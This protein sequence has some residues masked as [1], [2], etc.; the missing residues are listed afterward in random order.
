MLSR[1]I[2]EGPAG[3]IG[4]VRPPARRVGRRRGEATLTSPWA[5]D[6]LHPVPFPVLDAESVERSPCIQG[7]GAGRLR[8]PPSA[9]RAV[10]IGRSIP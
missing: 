1:E 6:T 7:A 2:M 3:S 4:G 8:P 5:I 9:R 10:R